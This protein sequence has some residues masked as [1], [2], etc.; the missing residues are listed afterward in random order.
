MVGFGSALANL[1]NAL[2]RPEAHVEVVDGET[3]PTGMLL[4]TLGALLLDAGSSV[5]DVR[6]ALE[7]ARDAAG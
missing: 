1:R 7:K 5:T 2:G 3:V 6:S 4:G